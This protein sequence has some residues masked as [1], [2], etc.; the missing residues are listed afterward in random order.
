MF[1]VALEEHEGRQ[2]KQRRKGSRAGFEH[3]L[4]SLCVHRMKGIRKQIRP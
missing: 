3:W 1:T 4:A 2:R